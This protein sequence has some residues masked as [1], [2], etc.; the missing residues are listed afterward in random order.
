MQI[1][2]ATPILCVKVTVGGF[3][4]CHQYTCVHV[5]KSRSEATEPGSGIWTGGPDHVSGVA[6][7]AG[8][9]VTLSGVGEDDS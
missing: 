4:N 1:P 2:G 5:H 3:S 9:W 8:G 7:V 6:M